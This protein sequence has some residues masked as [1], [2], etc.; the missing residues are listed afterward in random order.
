[1]K[2]IILIV[3]T[4]VILLGCKKQPTA[5]FTL[6]K[7]DYSASENVV[8]TNY[9]EDAI[10]CVWT[11]T[12]P[13][14]QATEIID[15]RP[16]YKVPTLGQDGN[17][18]ISL[19]TFSKKDKKTSTTSREFLV[20][21]VRGTLIVRNPQGDNTNLTV[22][23]DNE[24]A[25]SKPSTYISVAISAGPHFVTATDGTREWKLT[26]IITAGGYF[27]WVIYK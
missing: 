16:L 7:L 24:L 15:K 12:D 13:S 19:K 25:N 27:D 1:M 8:I 2:N 23:V 5:E 11:I 3:S 18:I 9:S 22:K 6:D 20:K 26:P 21:T 14:G 4:L 17:Y 10:K